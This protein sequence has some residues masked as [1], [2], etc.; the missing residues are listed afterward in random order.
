MLS[1]NAVKTAAKSSWCFE[2]TDE[3]DG[4]KMVFARSFERCV[5]LPPGGQGA[6]WL[7]DGTSPGYLGEHGSGTG[8]KAEKLLHTHYHK[9]EC[10]KFAGTCNV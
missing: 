1:S 8:E 6:F 3:T 4:F 7:A 9:R 10:Y 5:F 2:G